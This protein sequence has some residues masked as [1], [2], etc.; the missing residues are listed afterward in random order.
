[1]RYVRLP[2][3]PRL[4]V[5]EPSCIEIYTYS[6]SVKTLRRTQNYEKYYKQ[7]VLTKTIKI[8]KNKFV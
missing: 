5:F 4:G 6:S 2:K 3:D 8:R 1:M 7:I